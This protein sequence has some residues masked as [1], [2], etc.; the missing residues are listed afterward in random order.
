METI[1]FLADGR[2]ED[3]ASRLGPFSKQATMIKSLHHAIEE[4]RL[5]PIYDIYVMP[6]LQG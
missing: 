1:D 5:L 4:L 3:L 6:Q 2:S